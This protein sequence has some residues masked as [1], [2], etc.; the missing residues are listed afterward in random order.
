LSD[1]QFVLFASQ[2]A[3]EDDTG[4]FTEMNDGG[5][6]F[7]SYIA[8]HLALTQRD[9][10]QLARRMFEVAKLLPLLGSFELEYDCGETIKVEVGEDDEGFHPYR[11]QAEIFCT[12]VLVEGRWTLRDKHTDCRFATNWFRPM[13][14]AHLSC[15]THPLQTQKG[16]RHVA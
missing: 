16:E 11:W 8:V 1:D 4:I 2:Q 3:D 14:L 6:Y 10:G 13:E 5:E 9:V 7:P 15:G 12:G